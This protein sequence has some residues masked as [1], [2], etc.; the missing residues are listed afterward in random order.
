MFSAGCHA[1]RAVGVGALADRARRFVLAGLVLIVSVSPGCQWL[2][3]S[4]VAG[5]QSVCQVPEQA[6]SFVE[7]VVELV[8]LERTSR[9]LEPL[10]V[11]ATLTQIARD[12]ACQM[13][14]GGF[15]AHTNPLTGAGLADRANQYGYGFLKIGENLAAGQQSPEQVMQAWM[16]SPDH[17]ANILDDEF[18]EIGVA[19]RTGGRYEIYWVQEFGLP[20]PN[21][22]SLTAAP[23]SMPTE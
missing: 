1:G 11:N 7:R 14:T 23:S 19:V 5:Q 6:E 4:G 17:A 22:A 12:Y 8:N 20:R 2:P 10:S 16:D 21:Q 18:V 3:G 15:F 9:G 13:I